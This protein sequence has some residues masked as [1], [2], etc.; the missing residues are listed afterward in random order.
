[1][2]GREYIRQ[3]TAR[4][5]ERLVLKKPRSIKRSRGKVG[6]KEVK[7]FFKEV[8]PWISDVPPHLILNYDETAF[9]VG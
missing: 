8:E 5:R 6:P 2:P 4:H 3:F 7:A 1:M 9:Q